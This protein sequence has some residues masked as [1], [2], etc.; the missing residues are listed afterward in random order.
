[1]DL[2]FGKRICKR[3]QRDGDLVMSATACLTPDNTLPQS[4][5]TQAQTRSRE[6]RVA[7][8]V[9]VAADRRRIF[10]ALTLPEYIETWLT[11]PCSDPEGRLV[12][13]QINGLFRFDHHSARGLDLCI[14]GAYRVCRRGKMSFTWCKWQPPEEPDC[15]TDSLV[16]IRLYGAF[17]KST[18]CLAHTGL[19]SE[20]EYRW[21][22]ELWDRSLR[23]LQSLFL[24]RR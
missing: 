18:L 20:N 13:S 11:I 7:L 1:M 10:D 22:G 19:F 6:R 9:T 21:H 3:K 17:A 12:A 15:A 8:R 23:K 14:G 24:A 5:G 4:R 16:I 2:V